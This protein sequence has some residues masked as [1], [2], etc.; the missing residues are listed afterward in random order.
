M[1]NVIMSRVDRAVVALERIADATEKIAA[2][3]EKPR[4]SDYAKKEEPLDSDKV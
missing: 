4:L 2:S 3:Q 1:V